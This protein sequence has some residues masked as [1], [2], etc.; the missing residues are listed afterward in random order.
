MHNAAV[1]RLLTSLFVSI[2]LLFSQQGAISH[3]LRHLSRGEASQTSEGKDKADLAFCLDCVAF[4]QIAGAAHVTFALP[5]LLETADFWQ[6]DARVAT[7]AA[8]SPSR[9]A[10]APPLP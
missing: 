4:A 5:P 8:D 6:S 2:A 1:R 10:R 7:R 3:E 9:R